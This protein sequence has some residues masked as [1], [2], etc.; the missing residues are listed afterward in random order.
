MLPVSPPGH[1]TC[2]E[3]FLPD[4]EDAGIITLGGTD[5]HVDGM[6]ERG[7]VDRLTCSG[8]QGRNEPL[9]VCVDFLHCNFAGTSPGPLFAVC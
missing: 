2:P 1:R 7:G 3:G 6:S 8:I 4:A 9:S 5:C